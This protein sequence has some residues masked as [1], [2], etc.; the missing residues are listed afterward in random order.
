MLSVVLTRGAE[1]VALDMDDPT[2]GL[3]GGYG[4]CTQD[5]VNL[6]MTGRAAT[7]LLRRNMQLDEQTTLKGIGA[8]SSC[9][10]LT[11]GEWYW[12][13]KV[14]SNLKDPYKPIWVVKS[15]SPTTP[16][17]LGDPKCCQPRA[18]GDQ[19]LPRTCTTTTSSP[20]RTISLG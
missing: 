19:A 7:N 14:G 10:Y 13:L 4:Y 6:P 16:C 2:C 17:C 18:K 12:H 5:L 11:A 3:I 15:R 9:G 1:R 20:I 8:R